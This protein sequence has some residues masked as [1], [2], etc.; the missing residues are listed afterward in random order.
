M[1]G[2]SALLIAI[3]LSADAFVVSVASGIALR[4]PRVSDAVRIALWFGLFQAGMPLIGWFAGSSMADLISASDHWVAF[5]LLGLVGGNMI[6]RGIRPSGEECDI[7]VVRVHGLKLLALA[8]A[9]SI[10]ALAVGISL[11]FVT[12]SIVFPVIVIGVTTF[13]VS[14][15]GVFLGDR[16]SRMLKEKVELAGGIILIGIGIR[17]LVEHMT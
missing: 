2:L 16:C 17:I 15:I 12:T 9:T 3:A 13:V 5:G 6:H 11:P 4:Q 7:D 10:D 8:I 14:F 1:N